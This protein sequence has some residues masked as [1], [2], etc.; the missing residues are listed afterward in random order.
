MQFSK[1]DW[2][3]EVETDFVFQVSGISGT[4]RKASLFST[5]NKTF[6]QSDCTKWYEAQ[7]DF[8]DAKRMIAFAES[9]EELVK[10]FMICK[11]LFEGDAKLKLWN[12]LSPLQREK[13]I[14]AKA[15]TINTETVEI[16]D[17]QTDRQAA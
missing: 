11:K 12:A 17:M 1:G 4:G 6:Y 8:E 15:L 3:I 2:V 9:S 16:K 14:R 7:D 10:V 13:M 5:E